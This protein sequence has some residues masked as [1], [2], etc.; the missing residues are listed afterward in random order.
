MTESAF[1]KDGRNTETGLYKSRYYAK[2]Q[3]PGDCVV[4][5]VQS[6]YKIMTYA[7]YYAWKK[8]K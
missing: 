4:V 6:G 3:C 7:D 1:D 8:Q 2:K 5:K